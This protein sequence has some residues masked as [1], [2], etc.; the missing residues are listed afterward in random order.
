MNRTSANGPAIL[1]VD[2]EAGLRGL[3][4]AYLGP[5]GLSVHEA[6]S[7]RAMWA[8]LAAH[9]IA[10]VVLDVG[11]GPESGLALL[12]ELRARDN[13]PPVVMLTGRDGLA[14][15]LAGLRRGADDYVTKPFEPRELLARIRAVLRR[16]AGD[17][18]LPHAGLPVPEKQVAVRLGR[19]VF[20]PIEG[21][22]ASVIDNTEVRLTS[23]E[24]EL[25]RTMLAH[26]ELVLSR[27]QLSKLAH[28]QLADDSARGI[29]AL[30]LRLRRRLEPNV[31]QPQVLRTVRG[32]GYMLAP[33]S[34]ED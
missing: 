16:T 10:L 20:D 21:R 31:R 29:D 5:R 34:Y 4:T 8:Q 3:L 7:G 22:L 2:D 18:R 25:L 33:G 27:A 1:V 19:C 15:C 28:R 23:M 11:L 32:Q 24:L 26:R 30:V 12:A 17:K 13:G 9:P 6:A 14:D